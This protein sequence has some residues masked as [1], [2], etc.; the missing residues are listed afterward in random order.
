MCCLWTPVPGTL[1]VEPTESEPKQELDRFI[2]AM[3]RIHAE[4]TAIIN[5]TADKACWFRC[6]T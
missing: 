6:F 5:G 3:E 4:I 2:E 1:M